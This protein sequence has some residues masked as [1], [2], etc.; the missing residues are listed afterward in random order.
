MNSSRTGLPAKRELLDDPLLLGVA[1]AA[2]HDPDRASASRPS[3]AGT[4][5]ASH[6]RVATRSEKTTTRAC[7]CPA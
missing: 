1:E 2:V 7:R 4:T 3:R 6:F 5:S